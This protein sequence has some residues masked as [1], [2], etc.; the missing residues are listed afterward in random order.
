MNSITVHLTIDSDKVESI[1]YFEKSQIEDRFAELVKVISTRR[2]KVLKINTFNPI[3]L[4]I[5]N[6]MLYATNLRKQGKEISYERFP[7]DIEVQC[8]YLNEE[9]GII[10]NNPSEKNTNLIEDDW[11]YLYDL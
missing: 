9:T 7:F 5:L 1:P 6:S 3:F 11:D 10:G 4:Y 2:N 8:K